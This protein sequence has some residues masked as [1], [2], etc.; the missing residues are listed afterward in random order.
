MLS[1][2]TYTFLSFSCTK[3]CRH[4]KVVLKI[5]YDQKNERVAVAR[6]INFFKKTGRKLNENLFT[7]VTRDTSCNSRA[8]TD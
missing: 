8:I 4:Q 3:G 6:A 7:L 1:S 2:D 5:I